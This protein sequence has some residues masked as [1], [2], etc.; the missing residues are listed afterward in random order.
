MERLIYLVNLASNIPVNEVNFKSHTKKVHE[1]T[2]NVKCEN[3][4][5]VCSNG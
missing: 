4:G 2:E 1:G 5:K 3:C